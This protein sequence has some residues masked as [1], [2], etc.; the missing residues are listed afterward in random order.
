MSICNSFPVAVPK[1]LAGPT[2]RIMHID[3]NR[4]LALQACE[5]LRQQSLAHYL[6]IVCD[7]NDD[8][9]DRIVEQSGQRATPASIN[10]R[11]EQQKKTAELSFNVVPTHRLAF[12]LREVALKTEPQRTSDVIFHQREA[13][14]AATLCG[15]E[16]RV[17]AIVG[18][19]HIP[20]LQRELE[21]MGYKKRSM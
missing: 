10:R 1:Q 18:C 8:E 16:G 17:L 5:L 6:R 4:Q 9:L 3:S 13:G 2:C 7:L 14:M 19:Q 15:F 12:I 20:G 21:N 11:L